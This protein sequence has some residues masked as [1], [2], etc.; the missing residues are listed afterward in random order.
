MSGQQSLWGRGAVVVGATSGIGHA[1][2]HTLARHGAGVVVN[3]R[4]ESAVERAVNSITLGGQRAI[5]IAGSAADETVATELVDACVRT[6]GT[7]DVL[8]NCAGI[9]EPAESSILNVTTG[10]WR[11]LLDSHLTTTFNTCRAAAPKMVAQRRGSIINTS[12]FAYLGDYGG[13]GYAAGKGAVNSLTL[14]VAAELAEYGVRA[15]VVCPGAKT[16]LSS[17]FAY[18]AKIMELYRRGMLD[19]MSKDAA[20]DAPPAE[21][22]AQLYLYLAGAQARAITG[23]IFVAAGGFLGRY[24]RP[25]PSILGFRDHKDTP[26]WTPEEV[27]K[28]LSSSEQ[29][30]RA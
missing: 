14:A 15:N 20:L 7:V 22:V 24:D 3:G 12:S 1:V 25:T 18:E 13:T 16:R 2:A 26:P 5:G 8:V 30:G 29:A 21:Y 4:H 6:F 17:G 19:E 10:D 23:Q 27:H 11:A 9:A 28:M